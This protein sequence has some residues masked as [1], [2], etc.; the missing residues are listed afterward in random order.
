MVQKNR[1]LEPSGCVTGARP[2]DLGKVFPSNLASKPNS[3]KGAEVV[4]CHFFQSIK[5]KNEEYD[6]L[7]YFYLP[8]PY[9]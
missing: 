8:Y 7:F 3:P 9:P 6:P 1:V 4:R 5:P 2:L